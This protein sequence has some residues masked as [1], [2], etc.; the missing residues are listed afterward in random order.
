MKG[1]SNRPPHPLP[2]LCPNISKK[3]LD[4]SQGYKKVA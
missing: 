4:Q 1:G 2:L 3:S